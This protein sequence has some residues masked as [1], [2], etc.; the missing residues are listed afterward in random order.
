MLA[1]TDEALARV[2]IAAS[3]IAPARRAAWLRQLAAHFEEAP[4]S[5][6]AAYTRI[7]RARIA[8]GQIV[9]RNIV[10]DET[11]LVLGLIDRGLLDP[12]RA[13]DRVAIN[14]AAEKALTQYLNGGEASHHAAR[15]YDTVRLNLAL[16]A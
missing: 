14:A 4:P 3:S 6:G 12:L 7:Y 11:M 5:R 2:V 1:L 8:A 16:A 13:E 15:I 10:V 9:L